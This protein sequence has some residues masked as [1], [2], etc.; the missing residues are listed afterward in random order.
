MSRNAEAPRAGPR[1]SEGT[2]DIL[3]E[4]RVGVS[5]DF[6]A[7]TL[8]LVSETPSATLTFKS[9]S[10]RSESWTGERE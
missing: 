5:V 9:P 4:S 3:R 1:R 8:P 2:S 7:Y 6:A 10:H